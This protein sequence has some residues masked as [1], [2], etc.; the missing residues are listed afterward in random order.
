MSLA[1][2]GIDRF[3]ESL[4]DLFSFLHRDRRSQFVIPVRLRTRL[5]EPSLQQFRGRSRVDGKRHRACSESGPLR[6]FVHLC[7]ELPLPGA[8]DGIAFSGHRIS[9]GLDTLLSNDL[10]EAVPLGRCAGM[11]AVRSVVGVV[12]VLEVVGHEP[13]EFEYSASYRPVGRIGNWGHLIEC[14]CIRNFEICPCTNERVM[15]RWRSVVEGTG[16]CR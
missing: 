1:R 14:N 16:E 11:N 15:P 9:A 5:E 3:G 10:D 6:C 12:E 4:G 2:D 8:D 7:D 13:T